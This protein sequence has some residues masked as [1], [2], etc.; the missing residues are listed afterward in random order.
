MVT[1]HETVNALL[2]FAAATK[3]L[4]QDAGTPEIIRDKLARLAAELRDELSGDKARQVD[5]AEAEAVINSFLP[6][7][8]QSPPQPG[9][10]IPSGGP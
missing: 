2:A 5:G 10:E 9:G 4:L 3:T 6:T 8:L 7:V 1:S